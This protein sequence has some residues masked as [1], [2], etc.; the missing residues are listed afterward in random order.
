MV[1]ACSGGA[2]GEEPINEF[3]VIGSGGG[4]N[5]ADLTIDFAPSN[6][7]PPVNNSDITPGGNCQ[8]TSPTQT[9]LNNLASSASC[10]Q[11]FPA[12]PN[13]DIPE[14]AI[15]IVFTSCNPSGIYD[16]NALCDNGAPVYVSQSTC[17]RSVS[18][19]H[20][21]LPTICSV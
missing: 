7:L 2:F 16:F 17:C 5:T 8:L 4:F 1:D 21:T 12:G 13:T 11:V 20:L 6:N 19:T 14:G 3:M 15:Y 10:T 9:L 18:Y